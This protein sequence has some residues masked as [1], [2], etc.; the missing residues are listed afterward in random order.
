MKAYALAPR[1]NELKARIVFAL[2]KCEQEM[3]YQTFAERSKANVMW[4]E[5]YG[6]EWV[7]ISKRKYFK[8]M[9]KY[10]ETKFFEEVE[11]NCKYFQYYMGNL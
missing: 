5:F 11:T 10:R 2:S 7:M 1:D 4:W 6:E 8:E 9:M 3:H